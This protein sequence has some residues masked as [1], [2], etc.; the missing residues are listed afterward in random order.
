[1]RL[2]SYCPI[3]GCANKIRMELDEVRTLAKSA[4]YIKS[5]PG[6][7]PERV[8]TFSWR[9]ESYIKNVPN[10]LHAADFS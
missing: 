3:S 8:G 9:V 10:L 7:G 4:R 2:E 1:M 6:K 5:I